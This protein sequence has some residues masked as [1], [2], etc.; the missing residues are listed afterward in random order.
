M[1]I[2]ADLLCNQTNDGPMHG[3]H[4]C[5]SSVRIAHNNQT[6]RTG[7]RHQVLVMLIRLSAPEWPDPLDPVCD[8]PSEHVDLVR[9]A[10]EKEQK[11]GAYQAQ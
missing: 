11:V 4:S 3:V 5:R 7:D 2:G 9:E 10:A 8:E 6:R 1:R